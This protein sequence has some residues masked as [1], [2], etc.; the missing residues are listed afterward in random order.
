MFPTISRIADALKATVSSLGLD[1]ADPM[2][3]TAVLL[4]CLGHAADI[5]LAERDPDVL[6][7]VCDD[8]R[9]ELAEALAF[10]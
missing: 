1:P 3:R 10:A 5:A 8:L 4:F 2:I 6:P 7:I 9:D